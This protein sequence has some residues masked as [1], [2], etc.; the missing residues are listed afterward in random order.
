M[1]VNFFFKVGLLR[2]GEA[3]RRRGDG[4]GTSEIKVSVFE[5]RKSGE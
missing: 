3:S 5:S 2:L 4:R 1:A